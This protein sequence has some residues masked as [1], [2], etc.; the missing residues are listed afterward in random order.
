MYDKMGARRN[1]RRLADHSDSGSESQPLL[2]SDASHASRRS[3]GGICMFPD[4]ETSDFETT[5][6]TE[7]PSGEKKDLQSNVNRRPPFYHGNTYEKFR[8]GLPDEMNSMTY[9]RFQYYSK[10]RAYAPEDESALVVP[11]HVIPTSVFVPYV[12]G[13][14][15]ESPK[16]SS[17]VT[18]FA[19]WNTIMGSSLLTMPWGIERAGLW[20]GILIVIL[21]GA[22]C[23]YTAYQLLEVQKCHGFNSPDG[24]VA[25]LSRELLGRPA[26]V[27]A[28]SFSLIVL[29]GATIVYWILMSNFI[30][31]SVDYLYDAVNGV[32][33]TSSDPNSTYPAVLCMRH[34]D[35]YNITMSMKHPEE[36]IAFHQIWDLEKTVPIFLI[37]I[38]APLINIKS[39]TF[40][41]KF[42]SLGTLS[43]MY[44]LIFVFVKASKWG[45]NVQL[46][47]SESP[48]YVPPFSSS[49]PA[50]SGMLALSLFIH[51]IIIS[52]MRNN[53]HQENN[54]RDLSVAYVLVIVTYVTIGV[55]FYICFPLKKSCIEDN[56]LNNF[57]N[58]DLMTAVARLFLFFQLVTVYPL[59][60]YMLRAQIFTALVEN[61]YP[62]F[63]HVLSLNTLIITVCVF[64][65]IFL[66]KIG[67]IIRFTGALSGLIYIFTLPSLLHLACLRKHGK[68]TLASTIFHLLIPV[69]G[70]VNLLS[71][72]F[73][74][75]H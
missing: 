19:V 9:N 66:P 42:N 38:I 36:A 29:L 6:T 12:P 20:T 23:L 48:S 60:T 65:A 74:S 45:I 44:L 49:F 72:F 18:I 4:S 22:L 33:A 46:S 14:D 54:G 5:V 26:E 41:T 56:L 15:Q 58:W 75:D 68:L 53:K 71:Q 16:Q 69:I 63:F 50:L 8:N 17:F 57:E 39:A 70:G 25:D 62:G 7:V 73:V 35:L 51:N 37:I 13:R 47:D 11:D 1:G 30:Y 34:P 32:V 2:S 28:K 61:E 55:V 3:F 52:I 10:L 59:I 24:E 31:H 27:V 40:F 67:A 43:I 64:F 21:M